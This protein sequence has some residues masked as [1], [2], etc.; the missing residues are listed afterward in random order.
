M[1][2]RPA[3]R[4]LCTSGG[5]VH[6]E[7]IGRLRAPPDTYSQ[8][9]GEH[10][11]GEQTEKTKLEPWEQTP[12][13]LKMDR[14]WMYDW[15]RPEKNFRDKLEKFIEAA[16]KDA[17]I[18]GVPR[19]CCPC[20]KYK[21]LE[22]QNMDDIEEFF[23]VVDLQMLDS[24]GDGRDGGYCEPVPSCNIDGMGFGQD[25]DDDADDLEEMLKH[26]KADILLE[27]AKGLEHFNKVKEAAKQS[28]YEESKG[29]LSHWSVLRP[30]MDGLTLASMIF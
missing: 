12:E 10:E 5:T 28:V 11:T 26:F 3:A 17:T 23:D 25:D 7:T 2:R 6:Q 18:K 22:D 21:N 16:K 4:R 15:Q 8:L 14:E 30:S 19:I 20:K 24:G 27:H 1:R 29:C 13:E 9:A